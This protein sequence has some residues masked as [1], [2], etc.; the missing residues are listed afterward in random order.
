[1]RSVSAYFAA[2]VIFGLLVSHSSAVELDISNLQPV[3]VSMSSS[4]IMHKEAIRITKAVS[5][6]KSDE[7]TFARIKGSSFS[8][9]TIEVKMLSRLLTDAPDFARGFIGIAFRI[10]E[11]NSRFEC[12]YLRPANARVEDQLRRNHSIQYFSY[13]D[14]KFERLRKES[15]EVYESYTDMGLNEWIDLK[16]EVQGAQAKLFVNGGKQPALIVQDLKHGPHASG[17]VG[18]WVDVGTEGYFQD[19]R[20]QSD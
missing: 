12:I 10:N 9:G 15:P 7:P 4:A 8:N 16:I 19:L 1:M 6:K 14:F 20:I 17:A 13:P 18:L 11:D 5:I 2:W 3:S